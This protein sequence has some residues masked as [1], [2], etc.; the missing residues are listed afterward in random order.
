MQA[1]QIKGF[2]RT[3][4]LYSRKGS[5]ASG[6]TSGE[7]L[8]VVKKIAET[9]EWDFGEQKGHVRGSLGNDRQLVNQFRRDKGAALQIKPK[10]LPGPEDKLVDESLPQITE[11]KDNAEATHR[12]LPQGY[13]EER[14]LNETSVEVL[15][16]MADR[17][18]LELE[19]TG[20]NA[21]ARSSS[22]AT[23]EAD[24]TGLKFTSQDDQ[25]LRDSDTARALRGREEMG[26]LVCEDTPSSHHFENDR[27]MVF[28]SEDRSPES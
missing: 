11:T 23:S 27:G 22:L 25:E 15:N 18:A 9:G 10:T 3:L 12:S 8:R 26:I 28:H 14:K 20:N 17:S 2:P 4:S 6:T 13:T 24:R 21:S 16:L 1:N 7:G 5:K 19:E